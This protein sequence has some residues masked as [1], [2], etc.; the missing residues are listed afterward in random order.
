[1]DNDRPFFITATGVL[2]TLVA[3]GGFLTVL[4]ML[5]LFPLPLGAVE[6]FNVDWL[7]ALLW[8]IQTLVTIWALIRLWRMERGGWLLTVIVSTTGILLALF[9]IAGGSTFQSMLPA[10]ILYGVML[11]FLILPDAREASSSVPYV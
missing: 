7:G 2:A 6:F 10:L 9:S 5:G 1:M 8:T 4:Q 11:F 3:I